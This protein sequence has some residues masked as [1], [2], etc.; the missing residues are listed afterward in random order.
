MWFCKIIYY[1]SFSEKIETLR[2]YAYFFLLHMDIYDT[3]SEKNC[4]ITLTCI[5][6]QVNVLFKRSKFFP[7]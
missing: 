4:N 3:L 7:L 1:S 5:C 2:Q 6:N